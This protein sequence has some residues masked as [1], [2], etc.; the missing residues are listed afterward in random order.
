[1]II[2]GNDP[3]TQASFSLKNRLGR[4]AWGIAWNLA[5][6]FTPR[7]LHRWRAFLLRRFGADIGSS[8]HI[9]PSVRIW[10]PWKLVCE[11][12]VGI[13]DR[14]IIYNMGAIVIKRQAT[15][16]QGAHLCAGTHD[17]DSPNFQLQTGPIVIGAD[18]WIC[19]EA[20]VGP[21][22]TIASGCVVGARAC[23]MKSITEPATVWAGMPA[24]KL[25]NRAVVSGIK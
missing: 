8:V 14:A 5:F 9:Y 10:A 11:D 2:Q 6:R 20:F 12:R 23:V 21:N 17:I 3:R 16:S 24:R 19:S 18:V 4:V 25:R 13:G 7:Q 22:V 15:I 1:M